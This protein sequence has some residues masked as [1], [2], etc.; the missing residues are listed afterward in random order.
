MINGYYHKI[1]S[2][3]TCD[4]E[5]MLYGIR[6]SDLVNGPFHKKVYPD[7]NKLQCVTFFDNTLKRYIPQP[8]VVEKIKDL[9]DLIHH[10]YFLYKFINIIYLYMSD[11]K[12]LLESTTQTNNNIF[13]D[14]K[15]N[16]LNSTIGK[17]NDPA[18]PIHGAAFADNHTDIFLHNTL[19]TYFDNLPIIKENEEDYIT[20]LSGFMSGDMM[21]IDKQQNNVSLPVDIFKINNKT[22]IFS[23]IDDD[24]LR[25]VYVITNIDTNGKFG[26]RIEGNQR[27]TSVSNITNYNSSNMQTY[28]TD[29][30][31]NS[32]QNEWGKKTPIGTNQVYPVY[33]FG[34]RNISIEYTRKIETFNN[35]TFVKN[36]FNTP[37]IELNGT[38]TY[39][40]ADSAVYWHNNV[41]KEFYMDFFTYSKNTT[42]AFKSIISFNQKNN[43][44]DVLTI[45]TAQ[46]TGNILIKVNNKNND[47]NIK[48]PNDEWVHFALVYYDT[49]FKLYFNGKL[50]STVN[51][52]I[53]I[54]LDNCSFIIGAKGVNAN[55]TSTNSYWNGFIH[56]I[57]IMDSEYE[58][59][60]SDQD[61]EN[62]GFLKKQE[63]TNISNFHSNNQTLTTNNNF[64]VSNIN[65][66]NKDSKYLTINGNN[67]GL[68]FSTKDK[69]KITQIDFVSGDDTNPKD[70]TEF[71]IFGS[72]NDTML[73]FD[74]T[75]WIEIQSNNTISAFNARKEKKTITINNNKNTN[76]IKFYLQM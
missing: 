56:Q 6:R 71:N 26:L 52:T 33:G 2:N 45:G 39:L 11:V 48:L 21:D 9:K 27:W 74:S 69:S 3:N 1:L 22:Y 57:K 64:K 67:S 20:I 47:T 68:L 34:I 51:E 12:F 24:F 73:T 76:T 36:D 4:I 7:L 5:S 30:E 10:N 29:A 61:A 54:S 31:N 66:N 35:P 44:Q 16:K 65:D 14:T 8:L 32:N 63:L 49:K 60:R 43:G 72:D 53:Q 59:Y 28:W 50:I 55:I 23:T 70:P 46:T 40:R 42:D 15:A 25:M 19:W 58:S 75:E 38:D 18:N 62:W 41:N 17:E 37:V 13:L